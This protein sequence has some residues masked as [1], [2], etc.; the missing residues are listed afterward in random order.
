M[1]QSRC[2]TNP[3]AEIQRVLQAEHEAMEKLQQVL[4]RETRLLASG[5]DM[6]QLSQLVSRKNLL[7]VELRKLN[8]K[9]EQLFAIA[10][11]NSAS[12][13]FESFL[14]E[15]DESG[16]LLLLWQKLLSLTAICQ[17]INQMN[18]AIINLNEQHVRQAISLLRSGSLSESNYDANGSTTRSKSSRFLGQA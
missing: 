17:E 18:G 16:A 8:E 13:D 10:Q 15:K 1:M 9:R 14:I 4:D 12:A 7:A 2:S 11:S 6:E 5:N 3:A